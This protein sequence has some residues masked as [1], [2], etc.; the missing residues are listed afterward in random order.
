M[1]ENPS[2]ALL[3]LFE[4]YKIL[5]HSA[6]AVPYLNILNN[7]RPQPYLILAF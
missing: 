3:L 1:E 7:I 2:R 4:Q 5:N 6:L